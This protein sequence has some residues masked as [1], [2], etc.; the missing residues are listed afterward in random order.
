MKAS[1]HLERLS[2]QLGR[3]PGVGRRTAE[4]MALRIALDPGGLL[5]DLEAALRGVAEEVR[6]CSRC[7][8]ITSAQENPCQ[9]CMDPRRDGSLLCV[10]EDPSDILLVEKSGG[11]N[12]RYHALMGRLS[13]A[14]NTGPADLRLE[15]LLQRVDAEKVQEV[16][17]ALNTDVESEATCSYIRERLQGR[18]TRVTRLAAGLPAG[19]GIM[20]TDSVTLARAI[21]GRQDL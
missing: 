11:F 18:R 9:L 17:L 21:K 1:E 7:G 2:A 5:A 20:Y 19:S 13:P 8:S 10:V 14:G 6:C 16:L 4:R 3:L 12:G 15:Q